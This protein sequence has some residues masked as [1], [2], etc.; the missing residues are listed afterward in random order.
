MVEDPNLDLDLDL[1]SVWS[2]DPDS[3]SRFIQIKASLIDPQKRKK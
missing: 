2:P 1:H 3:E